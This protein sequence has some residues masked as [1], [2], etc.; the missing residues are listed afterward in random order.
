MAINLSD[1]AIRRLN[2]EAAYGRGEK[3][4]VIRRGSVGSVGVWR[5]CDIPGWH[6]DMFDYRVEPVEV[7]KPTLRTKAEILAQL[8]A[9]LDELEAQP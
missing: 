6:W 5:R 9:M 4:Q 3:I 1:E 2:I 8:R 7:V